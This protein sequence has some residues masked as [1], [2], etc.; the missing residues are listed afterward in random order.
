M[1]VLQNEQWLLSLGTFLP[2]AGV[3]V[4]LCS[5]KREESPVTGTGGGP[6]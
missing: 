4:M 1:E 2:I 5:P 3:L 6:D